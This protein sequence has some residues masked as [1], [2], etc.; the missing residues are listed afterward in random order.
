M[1]ESSGTRKSSILS[2]TSSEEKAFTYPHD[3]AKRFTFNFT[4]RLWTPC[5]KVLLLLPPEKVFFWA[6]VI[7]QHWRS[8]KQFSTRERVAFSLHPSDHN[9]YC[10]CQRDSHSVY[11]V[12][13]GLLI[14]SS[15]SSSKKCLSNPREGRFQT[16]DCAVPT[17]MM[18]VVLQLGEKGSNCGVQSLKCFCCRS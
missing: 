7:W 17:T 16:N 2:R 3:W 4:S 13:L 18:V 1:R 6:S 9:L 5:S 11:S 15:D 10:C 12:C 8:K 14:C